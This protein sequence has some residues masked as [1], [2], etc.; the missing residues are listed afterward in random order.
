MRRISLNKGNGHRVVNIGMFLLIVSVL[1]STQA[2][3]QEGVL[4]VEPSDTTVGLNDTFEL[5]V[6]VDD[7]IVTLKGYDVKITFSPS[8]LSVNTVS[9]GPLLPSGGSTF[10]SWR[11]LGADTI[12]ITDAILGFHLFV[13]GPGVLAT[14][15]F[16][17]TVYGYSGVDFVYSSL[18]DT[19]NQ[20]PGIP[21]TT[22]DGSVLVFEATAPS[23]TVVFPNGGETLTPGTDTTIRWTQTD[24]IGVVSDTV[25]YS[26]DGGGSW[27]FIWGGTETTTHRWN[28]PA[29]SSNAC[30]IKVIAADGDDNVAADVSNANFSIE[31]AF[32]CGDCNGDGRVTI[33]DA[34]YLVAFIYRGGPA[35]LGQADVNLDTRVT[36]A[37]ATY[38]VAFIYRGGPLPCEPGGGL[39]L[40]D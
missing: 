22:V 16:E 21:H 23:V 36:I 29:T 6:T 27:I 15:A 5:D 33:A 14:I 7:N 4:A 11:L 28:V 26:V 35:P 13:D 2:T 34:T 1:W 12:Q 17:S 30:R 10:F 24:D 8:V 19:T 18:R 25:Y 31:T 39:W 32:E 20:I 38:L 37:D 3:S 40:G 9:E